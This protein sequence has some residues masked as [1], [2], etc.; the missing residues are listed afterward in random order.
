MWEEATLNK[1]IRQG[2]CG[3]VTSELRPEDRSHFSAGGRG[4]ARLEARTSSGCLESTQK[5]QCGW[6]SWREW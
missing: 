4:N 2:L 6:N 1:V 3:E 5:D